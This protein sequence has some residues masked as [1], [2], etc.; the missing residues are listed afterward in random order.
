[1]PPWKALA[2]RNIGALLL[3]SEMPVPIPQSRTVINILTMSSTQAIIE[4][5]I[6]VPGPHRPAPLF[7]FFSFSPRPLTIEVSWVRVQDLEF[8][9]GQLP[10]EESAH[11]TTF[12][13]RMIPN[14]SLS[15]SL[16]PPPPPPLEPHSSVKCR[17]AVTRFCH[18]A[19]NMPR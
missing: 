2:K 13:P 16:S 4:G 11:S 6:L 1:M 15:L 5:R 18:Q 8:Y 10:A 3:T 7:L 17:H 9:S 19:N 14:S 12:P